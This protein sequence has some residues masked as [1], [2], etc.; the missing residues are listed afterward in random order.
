VEWE[1][2][3]LEEAKRFYIVEEEEVRV[4]L[5]VRGSWFNYL[6]PKG[7]GGNGVRRW[8]P[9]YSMDWWFSFKNGNTVSSELTRQ[10]FAVA[11]GI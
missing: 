3:V 10:Q 8:E 2:G 7:G 9:K 4:S 6:Q 11:A 5:R 1:E